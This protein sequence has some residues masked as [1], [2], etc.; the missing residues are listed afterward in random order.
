M[1][2]WS[3]VS[4]PL[5][6]RPGI[7]KTPRSRHRDRFPRGFR[8]ARPRVQEKVDDYLGAGSKRVW[9]IWPDLRAVTVHR[10]DGTAM[11]V[12]AQGR[13]SSDALGFDLEDFAIP[14]ADIFPPRD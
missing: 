6:C 1:S 5:P 4:L 2:P 14:V 13:L 3:P 7:S 10:P 12:H 8:C 11:T 9:V